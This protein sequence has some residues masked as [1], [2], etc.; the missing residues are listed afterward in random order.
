MLGIFEILDDMVVYEKLID[1]IVDWIICLMDDNLKEL[2]D[3]LKKV[4]ERKLY[5]C[6]G[7]IC[8]EVI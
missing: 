1:F 5:K 2:R 8:K 7:Y 4:K 6:V 3:I